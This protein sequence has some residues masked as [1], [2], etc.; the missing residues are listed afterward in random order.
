[1]AFYTAFYVELKG[2][3]QYLILKFFMFL[4]DDLKEYGIIIQPFNDYKA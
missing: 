4:E 3:R 1:M 2:I